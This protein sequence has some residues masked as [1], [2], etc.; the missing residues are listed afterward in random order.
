MV[1]ALDTARSG[2]LPSDHLRIQPAKV[3]AVKASL[4]AVILV[5]SLLA[6]VPLVIHAQR[7]T[8]V[9]RVGYLGLEPAPSAYLEAF[10]DGLRRLGYAE[11]RDVTV[12]S[13]LAEGKADRLPAL[14]SELARLGVDVIV[15]MSGPT[16][17]VARAVA[18]TLPLVIGVSGDPVEAGFVSSLARPGGNITGMSYLQP[19]LAGKRLQ[20]LR[21]V[22]PEVT[23]VALLMNPELLT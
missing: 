1:I 13:R 11:G 20:L 18:P 12:E 8:K 23:R 2:R 7:P 3:S 9:F 21:E 16:A 5:A 14:A 10:R 17:R 4:F 19:D 15:G 22:T 6:A